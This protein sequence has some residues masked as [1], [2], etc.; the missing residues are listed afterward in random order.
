ML[1]P[2]GNFRITCIRLVNLTSSGVHINIKLSNSSKTE[3]YNVTPIDMTMGDGETLVIDEEF[4]MGS[5]DTLIGNA[6]LD[7]SINFFVTYEEVR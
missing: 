4:L 7:N 3:E 6:S 1:L 2:V 5:G